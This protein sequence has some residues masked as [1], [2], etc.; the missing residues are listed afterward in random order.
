MKRAGASEQTKILFW[1]SSGVFFLSL[2]GAAGLVVFAPRLAQY[3]VTGNF[4]YLA[5][6]PVGLLAAFSLFGALRSYARYEGKVLNG[7][8]ELGGP[9]VV[10]C[11]V[12]IGAFYLPK[13]ESTFS[14]MVRLSGPGGASDVIKM[15]T[16]TVDFG[17][18]RRTKDVT[19]SGEAYFNEVPIRFVGTPV[20]V[21][22]NVPNY[23]LTGPAMR[24]IPDTHTIYLEMSAAPRAPL[25]LRGLVLNAAGRGLDGV[26][27]SV[28]GMS[29]AIKTD[30][31]G[32]FSLTLAPADASGPVRLRAEK[33]GRVGFDDYVTP[34]GPITIAF[35]GDDQ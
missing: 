26:N 28:V 22:A 19:S 20:G 21:F 30:A 10:F 11:L 1:A 5:V 13:P 4:F 29:Q 9:V 15:G 8:L 7:S 25:A 27:L 6:V 23:R 12:V 33:D 32:N 24:P 31:A 34:P 2:L 16:V 14:L 18:D 17:T 35:K 3:G